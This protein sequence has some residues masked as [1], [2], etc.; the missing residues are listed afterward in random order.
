MIPDSAVV[1]LEAS[2]R[3]CWLG[4]MPGS[5]HVW[6]LDTRGMVHAEDRDQYLGHGFI[7]PQALSQTA[8]SVTRLRDAGL[9][10]NSHTSP[11][12]DR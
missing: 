11:A 9:G 10:P 8:G 7:L 4:T 12:W 1:A 3:G 5:R 6:N 2:S